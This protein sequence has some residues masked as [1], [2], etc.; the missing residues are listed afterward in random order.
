[1]LGLLVSLARPAF[2]AGYAVVAVPALAL[3]VAAGVVS[4]QR[5]VALGLV[6]RARGGCGVPARRVVHG[7]GAEDWRG[8]VEAIRAEQRAGE[9]VI[10]LPERQ[11]RSYRLLRGR[12]VHRRP[13]PGAPRLAAAGAGAAKSGASQLARRLVRPPRYALLDDRRYGDGL[14]LQIWAEP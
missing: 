3:L 6:G 4:Q 2:D 11:R 10:V 14:W 1:M 7:P 9:A 8:A 12:R 13:A 5:W